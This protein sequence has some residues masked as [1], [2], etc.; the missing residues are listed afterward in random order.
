MLENLHEIVA[1]IE[2]KSINHSRKML[3]K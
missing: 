3:Y 1:L 2:Q